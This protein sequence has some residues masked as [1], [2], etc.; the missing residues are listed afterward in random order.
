MRYET[1]IGGKKQSLDIW[2]SGDERDMGY[3]YSPQTFEWFKVNLKP[4]DE[5]LHVLTVVP[6][7]HFGFPLYSEVEVTGMAL[8]DLMAAMQEDGYRI[9]DV[10]HVMIE[11]SEHPRYKILIFYK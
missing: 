3:I 6:F 9:L 8:E 1:T 11:N 5:S 10:Q 7:D 4:S 2:F